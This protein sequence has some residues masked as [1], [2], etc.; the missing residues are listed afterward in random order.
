MFRIS[1]RKNI[2]FFFC[3]FYSYEKG[4]FEFFFLVIDDVVIL[5]EFKEDYLYNYY[6]SKLV[7]GF[8]FME[9]D[10]VIKEGDG[11]RF[12]DFYR[13]VLFLFKVNYKTK[14]LYVVL[15]YLVKIVGVL[16]EKDVY[17]LMWNRF[18]N[19]YGLKGGNIF[20]DL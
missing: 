5:I 13:F 3:L 10:D 18:F 19:K 14:Y 4:Y 2:N 11:K 17:N 12:Y 15:L 8:I 6:R 7:L 16:L 1:V 9:F 20:L